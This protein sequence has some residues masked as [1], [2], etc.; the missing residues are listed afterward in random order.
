MTMVGIDL[1]MRS[2]GLALRRGDNVDL[3]FIS[4]RKRDSNIFHIDEK[5]H[6]TV[7]NL[8][9][10]PELVGSDHIPHMVRV[11]DGVLRELSLF[12]PI[13]HVFMEGYAYGSHSSSSAKMCE[14]GGIMKAGLMRAGYNYTIIAPTSLKLR[15]CGNGRA[16]K[17]DMY[18]QFVKETGFDIGLVFNM[19]IN[20]PAVPNPLQDMVDAYALMSL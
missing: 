14:L 12:E 5:S 7:R 8:P 18:R 4:N 15:F 1:S 13:T 16:S 17:F 2:P 10:P 6:I 9:L 3:L 19:K 11:T 20:P